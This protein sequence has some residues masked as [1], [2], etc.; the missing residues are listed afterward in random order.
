MHFKKKRKTKKYDLLTVPRLLKVLILLWLLEAFRELVNTV[1]WFNWS[2]SSIL[3]TLSIT[4]YGICSYFVKF[5]SL[6]GCHLN[7]IWK[8]KKVIKYWNPLRHVKLSH[9]TDSSMNWCVRCILTEKW[10]AGLLNSIHKT[11]KKER[12]LPNLP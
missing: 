2:S 12:V 4:P 7:M 11:Q 5:A 1:H 8:D 6:V 9:S 10:S 3:Q